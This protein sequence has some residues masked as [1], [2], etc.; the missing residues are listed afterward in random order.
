MNKNLITICLILVLTSQCFATDD[1]SYEISSM[2]KDKYVSPDGFNVHD[3][4]VVQTGIT[5]THEPSDWYFTFWHSGEAG[6]H[7]LDKEN[8]SGLGFATE[9][10]YITGKAFQAYGFDVDFSFA[11]WDLGNQG[12]YKN[13]GSIDLFFTRLNLG[14]TFE[15]NPRQAVTLYSTISNYTLLNSSKG[16][17]WDF[18]VGI[19][20]TINIDEGIDWLLGG[21]W[22]YDDG[23]IFGDQGF[24]GKLDT[25]LSWKLPLC[26]GKNTTLILPF[27]TYYVSS[28]GV[29]DQDDDRVFGL[30]VSVKF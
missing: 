10:N 14:K 1:W 7:Y 17:G 24:N 22:G 2:L 26:F 12:E 16:N 8:S 20:Q 15:I 3:D 18:R 21:D 19:S 23:Y 11:F 29:G 5:M 25:S 13:E 28:P 6:S 4:W 30:G 27:V 9:T